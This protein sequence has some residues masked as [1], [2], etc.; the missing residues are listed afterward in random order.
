[1][2]APSKQELLRSVKVELQAELAHLEQATKAALSAAT[3]EESRPENEYDT[4]ALEASYLAAA[5]GKRVLELKR[6][7][8]VIE[9]FPVNENNGPAGSGSLVEVESEGKR[10]WY[11]LLPFGA[12]VSAVSGGHKVAV[13]TLDSPLGRALLGKK[14][15]DLA[16]LPR[17]GG[18]KEF[19]ILGV[20]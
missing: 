20:F 5:Q 6:M 11:F 1:L 18:P 4:R 19:E 2:A 7:L 16:E 15:G 3:D 13:V 17:P 8:G 9:A 12:G 14:A 10:N